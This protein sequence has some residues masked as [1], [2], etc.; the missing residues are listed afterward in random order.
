[1]TKAEFKGMLADT[2]LQ[3]HIDYSALVQPDSRE[4]LAITW[5]QFIAQKVMEGIEHA[6]KQ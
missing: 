2:I 5:E 4:P 3:G 6:T 1:M